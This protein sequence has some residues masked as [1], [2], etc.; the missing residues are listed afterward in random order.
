MPLPQK[1]MSGAELVA[2]LLVME[3]FVIAI[4]KDAE[5]PIDVAVMRA[6]VLQ[7]VAAFGRQELIDNAEIFVDEISKAITTRKAGG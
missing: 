2:R 4:A 3:A 5:P 6:E 1:P 7:T